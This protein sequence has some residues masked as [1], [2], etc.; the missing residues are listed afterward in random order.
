MTALHLFVSAL[1]EY[2]LSTCTY[3]SSSLSAFSFLSLDTYLSF[4]ICYILGWFDV[5]FLFFSLNSIDCSGRIE[6]VMCG[7]P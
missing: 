6:D 4:M 2:A 1:D 7:G 3:I 5:F